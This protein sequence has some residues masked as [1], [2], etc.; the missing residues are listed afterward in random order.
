[1]NNRHHTWSSQCLPFILKMVLMWLEAQKQFWSVGWEGFC[2]RI[3]EK[4]DNVAQKSI[5][6]LSV[7]GSLGLCALGVKNINSLTPN[8]YVS[9]EKMTWKLSNNIFHKLLCKAFEEQSYIILIDSL[10]RLLQEEN[11]KTMKRD[12]SHLKLISKFFCNRHT[13]KH[14][15]NLFPN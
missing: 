12:S 15:L 1:M 13:T 5:Y 2:I 6:H 11:T 9:C 3:I 8:R 10:V 4:M 7:N 14:R